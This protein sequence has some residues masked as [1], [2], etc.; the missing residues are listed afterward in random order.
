MA[1]VTPTATPSAS[2]GTSS[3]RICQFFL[4]GR[5][6]REN[7]E[8]KHDPARLQSGSGAHP[9]PATSGPSVKPEG[10][11]AGESAPPREMCREFA[12]KKTCRFKAG[13][14][15]GH[16]EEKAGE[17]GG[18]DKGAGPKRTVSRDWDDESLVRKGG[19]ESD[20][21]ESI[22]SGFTEVAPSS[23]TTA[24]A[25][26][27]TAAG[28]MPPPTAIPAPDPPTEE[29]SSPTAP[30][31][32]RAAAVAAATPDTPTTSTPS[33]PVV[34]A[35]KSAPTEPAPKAIRRDAQG[36]EKFDDY[37]SDSEK[38]DTP[39]KK[40]VE[41]AAATE[42]A[43]LES[44]DISAEQ[45]PTSV[46]DKAKATPIR[47]TR[48]TR[49]KTAAATTETP[50]TTTAP[51]SA[52]S[53]VA[54]GTVVN[55]EETI[56]N[57][58]NFLATD[59]SSVTGG[60]STPA[61][62]TD[63][64]VVA[65]KSTDT[66]AKE[67][68]SLIFG[69]DEKSPKKKAIPQDDSIY[70]LEIDGEDF[71]S[72]RAGPGSIMDNGKSQQ[73]KNGRSST[74][75]AT[76]TPHARRV[77]AAGAAGGSD[78]Q[79]KEM[80][81]KK[82]GVTKIGNNMYFYSGPKKEVRTGG[83]DDDEED[84][85]YE[86]EDGPILMTRDNGD[87]EDGN[88]IDEDDDYS[89][90]HAEF[91]SDQFSPRGG[92]SKRGGKKYSTG[93]K[94]HRTNYVY[95]ARSTASKTRRCG[96][97]EGCN[98]D[99]CQKCDP[100]KDKPKFGG[101]GTKK[102]ACIY[103]VCMW[104]NPGGATRLRETGTAVRSRG[105]PRGSGRGRSD[106]IPKGTPVTPEV[107]RSMV[108]KV[109]GTTPTPTSSTPSGRG[110]RGRKSISVIS[111]AP[112]QKPKDEDLPKFDPDKFKP[113][114]TP[115][116]VKKGDEEYVVV[117]TGVKDTGLCG[118]YWADM[119]NLPKRRTRKSLA[120]EEEKAAAAAGAAAGAV[121][122]APSSTTSS[123]SSTTT[124]AKKAD[125]PA[126]RKGK[127]AAE[128]DETAAAEEPPT[129]KGPQ[130]K[131]VPPKA[132]K[133]QEKTRAD[134][135]ESLM[136][137]QVVHNDHEQTQ[138]DERQAQAEMHFGPGAKAAK[139]AK[140]ASASASV[141]PPPVQMPPGVVSALGGTTPSDPQQRTVPCVADT[142]THKE[143]VVECFAPYD[144]H[145]WVNIGK[146]R[147]GMA[148]D[149]VQYARAL[150]PPYHLLSFLR[151]KGYSTKGMSCTDK[152]TMVF[153]VLEGEITVVLHTTQFNAKK[154]DSFYIPPKNYY[155]LINQKAREAEL[156]LIQFQYDGPL[157]TVSA[158][159]QS[160]TPKGGAAPPPAA[161]S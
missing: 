10:E 108:S 41:A 146:E 37:F 154:G 125:T 59:A 98:R 81:A 13:C 63:P 9:H 121:P 139:T 15:F 82:E 21:D 102:Q 73:V 24:A 148:P 5:C 49:G 6:Q 84:E 4:R 160:G 28:E 77:A 157:P 12:A 70:D 142:S 114:Y 113:G 44:M 122:S 118:K 27:A 57:I 34:V 11:G 136:S 150:R 132:K 36:F 144:D 115:P 133:S 66:N 137:V 161:S 153:V 42:E 145:R 90:R 68:V 35:S 117:V 140:T 51:A 45:T 138:E 79:S 87:D 17:G 2:S 32:R 112:G 127:R 64:L 56:E 22:A 131:A 65:K 149:A 50:T 29:A 100:C 54:E 55:D 143:V 116:V 26:P 39:Q 88:N 30:A 151:I 94:Q 53:V 18:D 159:S 101:H 130:A 60:E 8:F 33:T 47:E 16:D 96:E 119:D 25:T 129:K 141:P 72:D 83:E 128:P 14:R 104:K 80:L 126:G 76:S 58:G 7:C 19:G 43:S 107:A 85:Y 109:S 95:G 156:S 123:S 1:S 62:G 3:E 103:R 93:R 48:A 20:D 75:M 158:A 147:D 74:P 97:C 92:H 38:E 135:E 23:S 106:G 120:E 91:E 111:P 155:N 105:R 69:Q 40:P 89:F 61:D 78:I 52:V 110:R 67:L 46:R 71:E 124:T 99:D 86:D 134:D 31:T 152:N